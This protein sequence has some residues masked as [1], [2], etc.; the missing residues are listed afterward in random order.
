MTH[1][2]MSERV[3]VLESRGYVE[4]RADASVDRYD[5]CDSRSP[6]SHLGAQG[7]LGP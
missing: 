5:S 6:L 2:S 4:R 1:Q 7:Q 3:G